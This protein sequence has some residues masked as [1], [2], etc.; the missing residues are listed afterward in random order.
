MEYVRSLM[1]NLSVVQTSIVWD[2][3]GRIVLSVDEA[4]GRGG[5]EDPSGGVG[6]LGCSLVGGFRTFVAGFGGVVG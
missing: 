2:V 1:Y 6:C 5:V 4:P 3:F